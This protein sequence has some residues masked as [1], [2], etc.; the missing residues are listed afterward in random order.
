MGYLT[1]E[2]FT[3]IF[4]DNFKLTNNAINVIKHMIRSGREFNIG[5]VLEQIRKNPHITEEIAHEL[6]VEKSDAE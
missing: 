4:S 5:K 3:D 1:N 6:P 2:R